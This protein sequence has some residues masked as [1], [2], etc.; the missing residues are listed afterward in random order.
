[1]LQTHTLENNHTTHTNTRGKH[2]EHVAKTLSGSPRGEKIRTRTTTN[3]IG[4]VANTPHTVRQPNTQYHVSNITFTLPII[5]NAAIATR[6][7]NTI[8]TQ[9][10]NKNN[11]NLWLLWGRHIQDKRK[12]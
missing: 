1:M 8:E 6:K 3:Q 12:L 10:T 9:F 2:R 4:Y 7:P 11:S 5:Q